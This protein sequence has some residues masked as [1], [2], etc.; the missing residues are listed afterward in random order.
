MIVNI[1]ENFILHKTSNC[2]DK[3]P[4]SKWIISEKIAL[5]KGFKQKMLKSN[6]SNNF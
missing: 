2:N 3:D 6:L 1:F 5:Y 4:Q